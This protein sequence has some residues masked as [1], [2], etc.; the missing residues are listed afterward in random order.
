MN[1]KHLVITPSVPVWIDGERLVFDRKFYDGILL[2]K[3]L[4]Q[5]KITCV[6]RTTNASLPAFGAV[7]MDKNDI[8]FSCLTL[9]CNEIVK[10]KHIRDANVVLASGDSFNQL[11]ISRLCNSLNI[12]C[13]YIIEY[14]PETRYQIASLSTN[15][16]FLK[17]R[18]FFY[19]WRGERVRVSAFSFADGLQA[20]GMPAYQNYK[21]FGNSILYF[22]SRIYKDLII[23]DQ[24]LEPRLAYLTKNEPLR[25]AF[26]GRLIAMKGAN[27]L[28]I[29]AALLKRSGMNFTMTVYGAGDLEEEMNKMILKHNLS[30][31]VI[32]AGAVDFYK[33]L[34]PNLKIKTDLFICLH[35]QS[36]PSCTYLETLSCGLPIVGYLNKAFSGILKQ[37][38]IG[39]GAELDDIEGVASLIIKLNNNRQEICIKSRNSKDF[40]RLHDFEST[41]KKRIQHLKNMVSSS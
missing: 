13:I 33:E 30:D 15:N 19:L 8:P 9:S 12:K 7:S 2:Y 41:Y 24:Q 23:N 11:H 34:I 20:N 4:W 39:W 3:K 10:D 18:R 16:V 25:L 1:N 5:G 38:D 14:I 6:M 32:M 22:A 37:A 27:Y 31:S 40:S 28:I 26:S 35:R 17:L 29:L 36:D 21:K